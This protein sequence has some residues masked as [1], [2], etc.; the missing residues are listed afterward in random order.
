MFNESNECVC[1][2]AAENDAEHDDDHTIKV[3]RCGPS[4]R[5]RNES[6]ICNNI[7]KWNFLNYDEGKRKTDAVLHNLYR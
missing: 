3:T 1:I 5:R 4:A 7:L 6:F 2:S